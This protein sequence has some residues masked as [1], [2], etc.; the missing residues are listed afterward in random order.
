MDLFHL[1]CQ[2]GLASHEDTR[3]YCAQVLMGME[4]VHRNGFVWRDLK[5][6]N[7]LVGDFSLTPV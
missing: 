5:P 4:H 1:L 7:V 6:E 3:S 2:T